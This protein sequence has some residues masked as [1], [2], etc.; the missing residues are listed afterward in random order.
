VKYL[1][2]LEM[3]YN[4]NTASIFLNLRG[5]Y[6]GYCRF[7]KV[8]GIFTVTKSVWLPEDVCKKAYLGIRY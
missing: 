5:I 7:G 6:D 1:G 8:S 4:C 2:S 3:T